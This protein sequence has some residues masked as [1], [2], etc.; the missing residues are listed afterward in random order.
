MSGMQSLID[1]AERRVEGAL[2][3]WQRL[4]AQYE[5]ARHKLLLL[6]QHGENYRDLMR[7]GLERGLSGTS[8][9]AYMGFIGQI[10][11][12]VLRQESEIGSLE[13]ACAQQWQ[14]LVDARREKRAYEILSERAANRKADARSR[15]A[16][17]DIDELLQRTVKAP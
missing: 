11:A 14:A 6:Q 9:M 15:R 17:A 3:S 7:T 12:I 5:E 10:E 2:T 16:Q 4:R 1:F 8:T 13:K